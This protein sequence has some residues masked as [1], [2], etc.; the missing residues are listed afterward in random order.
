MKF[1]EFFKICLIQK[2]HE[3]SEGISIFL[4]I[5]YLFKQYI[6]NRPQHLTFWFKH[7]GEQP[8]IFCL[9]KTKV[10]AI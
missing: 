2:V 9:I 1:G 7:L 8:G 6:Y 3:N 10:R 4:I 5:I